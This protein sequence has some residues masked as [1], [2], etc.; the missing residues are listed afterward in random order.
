MLGGLLVTGR[1]SRFE[2]DSAGISGPEGRPI[3]PLTARCLSRRGIPVEGH[4]SRLL[5]PQAVLRADL[6]LVAERVQ[7][8]RVA[9]LDDAAVSRT[10]TIREFARLASGA[11][12][13]GATSPTDLVAAVAALRGRIRA[14]DPAGDDLHDPVL[15]RSDDHEAIV[16]SLQQATLTIAESIQFVD[17]ATRHQGVGGVASRRA[18]GLRSTGPEGP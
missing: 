11:V 16:A 1:E 17:A 9:A 4:A 3:H 6:I 14:A 12:R 8:A 18:W 10:F 5:T 2:L 7:R 13:A 15:G